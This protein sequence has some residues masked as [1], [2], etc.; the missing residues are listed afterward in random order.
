MY[1]RLKCNLLEASSYNF[2]TC[3]S[4]YQDFIHLQLQEKCGRP[5][6]SLTSQT[7]EDDSDLDLQWIAE[8]CTHLRDY[9]IQAYRWVAGGIPQVAFSCSFLQFKNS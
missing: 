4:S 7:N 1:V 9:N 8:T 5:S 3:Y 2:S 6:L